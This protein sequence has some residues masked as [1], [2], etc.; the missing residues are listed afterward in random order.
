MWLIGRLAPDHK[1][2]AD[3]RKDHGCAI[4]QTCAQFGGLCREL[5]LFSKAI[6]ALDS[7]TFKVVNSRHNNF[8]INKV[9]KRSCHHNDRIDLSYGG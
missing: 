2:N 3:F 1:T 5:G 8:T 6:V 7:T 4:Q 9:I